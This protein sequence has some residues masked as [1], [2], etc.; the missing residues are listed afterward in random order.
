MARWI[1]AIGLYGPLCLLMFLCALRIQFAK[2]GRTALLLSFCYCLAVLPLLNAVA[3]KS[4]W[5]KIG[6]GVG[7]FLGLAVSL[8]IGWAILWGPVSVVLLV[9]L[10][11]RFPT[12]VAAGIVVLCQVILD[13]AILRFA[14][15]LL[16]LG[17]VW[18]RGEVI[19]ISTVLAPSLY[20]AHITW[21]RKNVYA[22]ALLVMLTFSV[23][24]FFYPV[25]GALGGEWTDLAQ[26][27]ER[28]SVWIR[29]VQLGVLGLCAVPG[30]LAVWEFAHKGE[31]TPL[32]F[33]PPQGLVTTGV[34]RFIANPMQVSFLIT[35]A[36]CSLFV[37]ETLLWVYTALMAVYAMSFAPWSEA[38]DLERKFGPSWR[39]YRLRVRTWL[40]RIKL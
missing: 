2:R 3:E 9:I 4:G 17:D 11:R 27:W 22:R 40:P 18:W 6:D 5:W 37:G 16:S 32:P 10:S 25:A 39:N 28:Q 26:F 21:L 31:G 34:Y 35:L 7:G 33:D 12:F 15:P 20:F 24:F 23:L 29:L 14:E 19:A 8:W 1:E 36:A 30:V 38:F 13:F